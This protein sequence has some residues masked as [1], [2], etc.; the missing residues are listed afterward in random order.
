MLHTNEREHKWS[1]CHWTKHTHTNITIDTASFINKLSQTRGH[2]QLLTETTQIR[3]MFNA[4]CCCS[5]EHCAAWVRTMN[6]E[7]EHFERHILW[8]QLT[9]NHN[10]NSSI[11][12]QSD[13]WLTACFSARTSCRLLYELLS[14]QMDM[15]QHGTDPWGQ[16]F[17]DR[18]EKL[19]SDR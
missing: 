12:Q 19:F 13:R 15:Q 5:C 14:M 18:P 1:C 17:G 7:T 2:N 3:H 16:P 6:H 4:C 11:V 10:T 8:Q 9:I